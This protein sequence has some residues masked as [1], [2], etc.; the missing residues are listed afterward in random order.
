MICNHAFLDG[1]KRIGAHAMLIFLALNGIELAYTQEELSD[2]ILNVASG[3]SSFEDL[4]L[5]DHKT[6]N[7]RCNIFSGKCAA[8]RLFKAA[9]GFIFP[10]L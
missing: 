9:G 3:D 8:S 7:M 4:G 10:P 6:S 2:M 1:N 5:V